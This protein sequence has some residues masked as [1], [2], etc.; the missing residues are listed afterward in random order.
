MRWSGSLPPCTGGGAGFPKNTE[1][2]LAY[3]QLAADMGAPMAQFQL[4]MVYGN[5]LRQV[6]K[7]K[8][9]LQCAARQNYSVALRHW[10][11]YNKITSRA[12]EAMALYQ[13]SVMAGGD[14][15]QQSGVV[16]H[17]AFYDKSPR[18]SGEVDKVNDPIRKQA[19]REL[20]DA[21]DNNNYLR[22]PRLNDVLP[23]PPA[24]VPEWKGIYS[25][26]S[27][28]DA[29]YYQNPPPPEFY[30][31]QVEA[32]GLLIPDQYLSQPTMEQQ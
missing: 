24:Q 9:L 1:L 26:M 32:A 11:G 10:G 16:L 19:Y 8:A 29:E 2:S 25:A 23:L 13:R 3:A 31:K 28:E 7:E 15:G 18:W 4:A 30:L 6:D 12:Q 22:F 17:G 21:L 20:T 5:Q 27:P 14:A